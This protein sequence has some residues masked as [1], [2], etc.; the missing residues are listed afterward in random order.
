[1]LPKAEGE[2]VVAPDFDVLAL[3][4]ASLAS[5]RYE[6][7]LTTPPCTEGVHWVVL[8]GR[9]ELSAAQINAFATLFSGPHFPDGNRRPV[10]PRH[11]RTVVTDVESPASKPVDCTPPGLALPR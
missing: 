3:L 10:K 4:P 8:A 6:G 11:G 7:S 9:L 1:V 5:Y 2:S